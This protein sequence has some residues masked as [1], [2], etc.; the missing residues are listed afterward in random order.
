MDYVQATEP[1][2]I[3][4]QGVAFVL[5]FIGCCTTHLIFIAIFVYLA[6]AGEAHIVA[7]REISRDLPVSSAMMTR[8]ATLT[9]D[10]PIEEAVQTL[11]HATQS[12]FPVVDGAAS[13]WACSA[14]AIS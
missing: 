4:G 6:A 12:E 7:I 13:W 11:L 1:S 14:A 8:Y 2:A 9:P 3:I 5:G 10:A